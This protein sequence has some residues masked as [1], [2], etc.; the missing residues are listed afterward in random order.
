MSE[1]TNTP[2]VAPAPLKPRRAVGVTAF[3]LGLLGFVGDLVVVL[4]GI[5]SLFTVTSDLLG[6]VSGRNT[7]FGDYG[8][9][10]I[11]VVIGVPFD[12]LLAVIALILGIVAVARNRGRTLGVIAIVLSALV[13]I[14]RILLVVTVLTNAHH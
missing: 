3:V 13:L 9:V 8:S 10:F 14:T 6:L 5:A 4:I 7:G 2:S 11:A 1:S 12:T